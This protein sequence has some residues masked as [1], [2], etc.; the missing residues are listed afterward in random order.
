MREVVVQ[1]VCVYVGRFSYTMSGRGSRARSSSD[2]VSTR[3]YLFVSGYYQYCDVV[4]LV[5]LLAM[6][7]TLLAS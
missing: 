1:F 3:V 4:Y 6:T 7:V 5:G 2:L